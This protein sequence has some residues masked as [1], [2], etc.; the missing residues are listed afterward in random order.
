MFGLSYIVFPW[1]H[2]LSE[3]RMTVSGSGDDGHHVTISCLVGSS[4]N[5]HLL[6]WNVSSWVAVVLC[7][8][9]EVSH[10]FLIFIAL[11]F[12][13][14]KTMTANFNIMI[15]FHFMST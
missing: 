8:M 3:L 2:L 1:C 7:L 12:C 11:H 9:T 5:N 4:I 14:L 13:Q 6:V 10:K 15:R